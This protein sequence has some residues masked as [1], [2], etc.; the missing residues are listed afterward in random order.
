M[1]DPS[2]SISYTFESYGGF[3]VD[4]YLNLNKKDYEEVDKVYNTMLS[5]TKNPSISIK[6]HK[7][8]LNVDGYNLVYHM[9][10]SKAA[11]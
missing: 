4:D 10:D 6:P 3:R 9:N 5:Y 7:L 2:T 1:D 8:S 11:E